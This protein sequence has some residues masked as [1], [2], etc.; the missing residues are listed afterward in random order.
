[1]EYL[2]S[3]TVNSSIRACLYFFSKID[4]LRVVVNLSQENLALQ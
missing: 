3:D 1:M 4:Y 2:C